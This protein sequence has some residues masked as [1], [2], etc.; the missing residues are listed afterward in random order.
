MA[1]PFWRQGAPSSREVSQAEVDRAMGLNY[2][3]ASPTISRGM[4]AAGMT[5][6][7]ANE[8][9]WAQ[10]RAE[11]DLAAR[12]GVVQIGTD[13]QRHTFARSA[14]SVAEVDRTA[15]GNLE[16]SYAR[17]WQDP[18]TRQERVSRAPRQSVGSAGTYATINGRQMYVP[19]AGRYTTGE[20]EDEL[21][22]LSPD[23]AAGSTYG[24]DA[25]RL[26]NAQQAQMYLAAGQALPAH[27]RSPSL[28]LASDLQ[29]KADM[30]KQLQGQK[31]FERQKEL[32][33]IKNSSPNAPKT[34]LE[35]RKNY[36][37]GYR[38]EVDQW[39]QDQREAQKLQSRINAAVRA[40][41]GDAGKAMVTVGYRGGKPEKISVREAR[42]MLNQYLRA[43]PT[44]EEY[45]ALQ[46]VDASYLDPSLG[47]SS[48]YDT[49][50]RSGEA[51]SFADPGLKQRAF[52]SGYTQAQLDQ[53]SPD[54]RAVAIKLLRESGDN[55]G[56]SYLERLSS[57]RPSGRS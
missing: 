5:T 42:D 21:K 45:A 55:E 44:R 46:G 49:A 40:A 18:A 39:N 28:G 32:A 9:A 57:G 13:G 27:L 33:G 37:E 19:K 26:R 29:Q 34:P 48:V 25:E 4:K 10:K 7:A 31:E 30:R 50:V 35:V 24:V 14:P 12:P 52:S 43:K 47:Q 51:T 20:F 11:Q 16:P 3:N 41:G 17:F 53:I 15:M 38:K 23:L 22:A 36:L 54:K 2:I 56:A 8:M 6:D 1:G